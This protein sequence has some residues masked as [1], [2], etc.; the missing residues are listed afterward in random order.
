MKV[1]LNTVAFVEAAV[2]SVDRALVQLV[3]V[4]ILHQDFDIVEQ[5][6]AFSSS[7]VDSSLAYPL[8]TDDP[9]LTLFQAVPSLQIVDYLYPSAVALCFLLVIIVLIS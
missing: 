2:D 5:K 6:N 3:Q 1:D 4:L 7:Q 9:L 8:H